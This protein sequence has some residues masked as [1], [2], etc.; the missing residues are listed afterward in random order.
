MQFNSAKP[1][2]ILS[3]ISIHFLKDIIEIKGT[4]D[5]EG[6]KIEDARILHLVWN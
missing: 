2:S 1:A 3:C 4:F 6:R 5:I